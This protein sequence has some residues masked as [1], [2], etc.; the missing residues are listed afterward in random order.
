M[1]K[2]CCC[3][4]SSSS[5]NHTSQLRFTAVYVWAAAA[6]ALLYISARKQT[7]SSR[8]SLQLFSWFLYCACTHTRGRCRVL[9]NCQGRAAAGRCIFNRWVCLRL[10]FH[11]WKSTFFFLSL[12]SEQATPFAEGVTPVS[13]VLG[14]KT[15][16]RKSSNQRRLVWH[17]CWAPL[18]CL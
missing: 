15:S 13:T 5:I 11:S 6:S 10:L 7:G 14:W 17:C 1:Y 8:S 3:T 2:S 16:S 4:P 9:S 18:R 12:S